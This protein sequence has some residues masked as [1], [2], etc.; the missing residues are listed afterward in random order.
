MA[1]LPDVGKLPEEAREGEVRLA[2][3]AMTKAMEVLVG[4]AGI[5]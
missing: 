3:V 1:E 2:Y 5:A 4:F